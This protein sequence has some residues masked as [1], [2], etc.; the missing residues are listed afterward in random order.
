MSSFG[1]MLRLTSF[2]EEIVRILRASISALSGLKEQITSLLRFFQGI[3][4]MVEFAAR[5]PCRDLLETL[6]T[7]IDRD[8]T[9]AI[10]GVTFRDFQK[11]VSIATD[12]Q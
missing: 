2:Q 9:G 5:G 8:E 1:K 4:G 11:Q 3:S 6:E 12:Q 10:A 7:G